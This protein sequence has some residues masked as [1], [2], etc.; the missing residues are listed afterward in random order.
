LIGFERSL[1]ILENG[2]DAMA[3]IKQPVEDTIHPNI[4]TKIFKEMVRA[5]KEKIKIKEESLDSKTF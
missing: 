1:K 5:P 2:V 3:Q 4:N